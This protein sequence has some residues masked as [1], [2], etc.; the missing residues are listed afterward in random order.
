MKNVNPPVPTSQEQSTSEVN[1]EN[2]TFEVKRRHHDFTMVENAVLFDPLCGK[3]SRLV[4]VY[5]CYHADYKGGSCYPS[6]STLSRET[7]MGR[8]TVWKAISELEKSG[9]IDI[10]KSRK[11]DG[12][13]AHNIYTLTGKKQTESGGGSTVRE[14]G[15]TEVEQEEDSYN[16]TYVRIEPS[17]TQKPFFYDNR[18]GYTDDEIQAATMI[19]GEYKKPV[20]NPSG[21]IDKVLRKTRAMRTIK[22]KQNIPEFHHAQ[23]QEEIDKERAET[24]KGMEINMDR[25]KQAAGIEN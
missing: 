11:P 4:Y 19:L 8:T 6:Y 3:A 21:F 2:E 5:L 24:L 14:Q 13:Y 22:P 25:V 16:K 15:S 10:I 17:K 18:E 12:G 9:H 20:D 23:P 1:T 7:G